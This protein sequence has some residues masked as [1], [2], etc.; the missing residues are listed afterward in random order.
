MQSSGHTV[1]DTVLQA[2]MLAS[3]AFVG[4]AARSLAAVEEDVTLP[5]FRAL[6]VLAERGPQRTVDIAEELQVNPSTGTRML[7][8]LIRK[9]LVRRTRSSRDRRV[10]HV[11]LTQAGSDVVD[12]VMAHRRAEMTRLIEATAE[13]W[14]PAVTEALAA[15]AV[16]AGEVSEQDWWLGWAAPDADDQQKQPQQTA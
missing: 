7:D 9:G 5:Q 3:R 15:F 8:R 2:L 12:R 14:Q 1:P 16:A 13:L 10:V 4:L 11:R 6:V